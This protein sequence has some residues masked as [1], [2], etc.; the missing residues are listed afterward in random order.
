MQEVFHNLL[1]EEKKKGT[2]IFYST[3]ILSD[4]SKVCDRVGIIKDGELIKVETMKDLS[5]KNLTFV[6]LASKDI[7]DIIKDLKIEIIDQDNN[8]IKFANKLSAN[9]LIKKLSKYDIEKILIEEATLEE[10]FLHYY[11]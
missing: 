11:K 7:E 5:K 2:T 6:K 3:H 8:E 4:I 1:K 10:M 9:D